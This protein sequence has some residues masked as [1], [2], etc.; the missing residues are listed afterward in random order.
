MG[1]FMKIMI[2]IATIISSIVV[3]VAYLKF[4]AKKK[5][6]QP[7][8]N[9]QLSQ[10]VSASV[11]ETGTFLAPQAIIEKSIVDH[12]ISGFE[13]SEMNQ[14]NQSNALIAKG[15]SVYRGKKVSACLE[16]VDLKFVSP[17]NGS[18]QQECF[19][20]S[21]L[22]DLDTGE[23]SSMQAMRCDEINEVMKSWIKLNNVE[24]MAL[25]TFAQ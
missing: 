24:G 11:F 12:H 7:V 2:L 23:L 20:V 21:Y 16:K 4:T 8:C 15:S 5:Q 13:L 22:S 19:A 18:S 6:F 3:A 9:Y 1:R 14:P 17:N 10:K 25:S